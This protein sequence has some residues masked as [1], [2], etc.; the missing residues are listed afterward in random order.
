MHNNNI[1][2]ERKIKES[3]VKGF[4]KRIIGLLFCFE[5]VLFWNGRDFIFEK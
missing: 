3:K 5:R 2:A 1:K 4:T